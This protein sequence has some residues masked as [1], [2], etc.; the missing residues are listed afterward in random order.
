MT[1]LNIHQR[2][3]EVMS[4]ISYIKK[5]D[6]KVNNQYTFISHDDV[7]AALHPLMV[8]HGITCLT[9]VLDHSQDGNRTGVTISLTFTNVDDIR[10][11]VEVHGFGHGIDPQDKGAGKALSYAAKSLLLKTF[12]IETGDRDNE[13]DLIDH[14]PEPLSDA[15]TEVLTIAAQSGRDAFGIA[16][17]DLS[18]KDR[19]KVTADQ[20][21]EFKKM[22][23]K[24]A[25]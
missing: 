9:S 25:A 4:E 16:W 10:E 14:K 19:E 18:V 11:S 17:K 15:L 21:A 1:K 23:V 6:K 7:T 3:L 24:N 8:K 2:I 22:A 12:M 13:A 20:I 5:G